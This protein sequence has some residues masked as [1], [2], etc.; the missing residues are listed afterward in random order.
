MKC[1]TSLACAPIATIGERAL[2]L[3]MGS[4]YFS[5][6]RLNQFSAAVCRRCPARPECFIVALTSR[7]QQGGRAGT[8]MVGR[9]QFRRYL[10]VV[11]YGC[12]APP[13]RIVDALNSALNQP[14]QPVIDCNPC[15]IL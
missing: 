9:Q 4:G 3:P 8:H 11:S 13:T 5:P 12:D 1:S 6:D 2:C 14:D 7:S 15:D 10:D